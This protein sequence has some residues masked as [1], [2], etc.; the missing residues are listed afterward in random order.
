MEESD[1]FAFLFLHVH[2]LLETKTQNSSQLACSLNLVHL[3]NS[4]VQEFRN[5]FS[6]KKWPPGFYKYRLPHNFQKVLIEYLARILLLPRHFCQLFNW[7][8]FRK[9]KWEPH[10]WEKRIDQWI[11][12]VFKEN[13][14][15]IIKL[16]LSI[17]PTS[18]PIWMSYIKYIS[19]F[20]IFQ[21]NTMVTTHRLE[22]IACDLV[23]NWRA[24]DFE[25]SWSCLESKLFWCEVCC[26]TVSWITLVLRLLYFSNL[27]YTRAVAFLG[28]TP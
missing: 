17:L 20:T 2:G 13:Q 28:I 16:T 4:P 3:I 25:I 21:T 12:R 8:N 7:Q 9:K 10:T 19:H 14:F 15:H 26:W 24:H 27:P 1:G 23:L 5:F 18:H 11:Q 6:N 22:K